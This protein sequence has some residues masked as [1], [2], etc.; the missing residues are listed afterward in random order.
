MEIW[1]IRDIIY[2]VNPVSHRRICLR[3]DYSVKEVSFRWSQPSRWR[4]LFYPSFRSLEIREN[5][6]KKLS[7]GN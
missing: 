7:A 6:F 5:A 3:H 2:S 4:P 1:D